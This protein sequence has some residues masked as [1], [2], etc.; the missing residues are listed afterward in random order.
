MVSFTNI[1]LNTE[2]LKLNQLSVDIITLMKEIEPF[3]KTIKAAHVTE[4]N[5]HISSKIVEENKSN[6]VEWT[7]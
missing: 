6:G 4:N 7:M 1:I 3:S 2:V 5:R